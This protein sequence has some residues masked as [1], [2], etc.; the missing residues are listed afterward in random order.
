MARIR[1][2]IESI[3]IHN[4][5]EDT[6]IGCYTDEIHVSLRV[7]SLQLTGAIG[8]HSSLTLDIPL[9]LY[10]WYP[11]TWGSKNSKCWFSLSEY[12]GFPTL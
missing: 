7:G 6:Y 9:V 2:Q 8:Q 3:W 4:A 12:V 1:I 10:I 11:S 5:A